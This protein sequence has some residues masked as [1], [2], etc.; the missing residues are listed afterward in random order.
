MQGG[1]RWVPCTTFLSCSGG[2]SPPTLSTYGHYKYYVTLIHN[3]YSFEI[4]LTQWELTTP[5]IY[6]RFWGR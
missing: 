6:E 4:I 2:S 3:I 5:T 1:V